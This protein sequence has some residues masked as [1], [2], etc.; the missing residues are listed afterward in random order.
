MD[1][2]ESTSNINF[3][4]QIFLSDSSFLEISSMNSEEIDDFIQSNLM[5]NSRTLTPP[6]NE[7]S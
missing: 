3:T 5:Q 1:A 2:D 6:Q 4:F 7:V